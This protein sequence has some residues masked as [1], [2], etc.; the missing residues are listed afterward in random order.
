M[1]V[2]D[3]LF[4]FAAHDPK[5][6]SILGNFALEALFPYFLVDFNVSCFQWTVYS[7]FNSCY[8]CT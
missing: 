5:G 3:V 4:P 6:V 2:D 1:L 8:V 7:N